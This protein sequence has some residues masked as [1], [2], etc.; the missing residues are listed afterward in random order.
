MVRLQRQAAAEHDIVTEGR[1]QGTVVFP[2]ALCKFY[3]TADHNE[4]AR[5][6]Q[7][8]LEDQGDPV[9]IDDLRA[10][11]LER[12]TRDK[13]RKTAPLQAALDAIEIDTSDLTAEQTAEFLEAI[14]S[15]RMSNRPTERRSGP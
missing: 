11:I 1:D 6:R 14:V 4:R 7:R 15:D 8:E 13:S 9:A 3:L 2:Q 5:R 10:Q 12:D